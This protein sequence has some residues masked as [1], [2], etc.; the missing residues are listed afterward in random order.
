M[1]APA[2][3][4]E[5]SE[6]TRLFPAGDQPVKAL[7]GV[8]LTIAAGEMVA[9]MGASGSGKSTLM[10][11]IG[12]LDR[13]TSGV[14]RIGGVDVS[15]L[16]AE[17]RA[18][19]R[20]AQLGFVF[21]RYHLLDRLTALENVALP[22]L[23]AGMP[24]GERQARAAALLG[25]LGMGERLDHR[26]NQLSGGQ[27]QRVA[28]ARALMNGGRIILADEPTGALD[29]KSGREVLALLAELHQAG[30][31][32][33]LVTH[34]AAVAAHAARVIELADGHVVAD[35]RGDA[36]PAAAAALAPP[37]PE[38]GGPAAAA[39]R[40][41]AAA[42]LA[43]R[44]ILA[45]RLR[46][47][48]TMLGIIIGIASVVCMVALGE[49][50]RARVLTD[51]ASIGT[52]TLEITPGA[53]TGDIRSGIIR[54]LVPGD[55]DALAALD[56]VD[57]VS[58][59]I[60][61]TKRLRRGATE[62]DGT[63]TGIGDAYF[64]VRGLNIVEGKAFS[65]ADVAR[66]SPVAVIDD[67][68]RQRL[69]GRQSPLGQVVFLGDTPV[70]VIGIARQNRMSFGRSQAPT[71]WLPYTTLTGRITGQPWLRN[72]TVRIKDEAPIEAAE[73]AVRTILL[74]RHGTADFTVF[75]TGNIRETIE[76]TR[77]TLSMLILSIA[78]ISLVVGGIGVMNI[79]LVSVT[80][81]TGEIGIRL[82]V[83]ARPSDILGQFL[84]EAVAVCLAGG[85]LGIALAF[86]VTGLVNQLAGGSFT[87]IITPWSVAAASSCAVLVGIVFG[88]WPARTAAALDPVAALARD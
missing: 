72:I 54:T 56:Y 3:L 24:A 14:C 28:I 35:R 22:G 10:N 23:Y 77:A 32:V 26:P 47:A 74:R 45:N 75:N 37:A 12:C 21:Q 25:R 78:A 71:V 48:L 59:G 79:M 36:A 76:S 81:R 51:L 39:G 83:G 29:S 66:R 85:L 88:L 64:R 80:E 27:A 6:V 8:S 84:A 52:N 69:F 49:G 43:G 63:L 67:N 34:D 87:M 70:T 42:R 15:T 11:L 13:P 38:H 7:D 40:L 31:T 53:E 19:L 4:I 30:H 55:A 17:G 68:A 2:P 58:P 46:A 62:I 1:T 16:D 9:I 20:R 73:Q 50:S 41:L 5:L 18:G 61:T 86:A 65:A 82:A 44:A 57:S 33:I 60:Q